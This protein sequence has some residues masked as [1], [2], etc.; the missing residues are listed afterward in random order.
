MC[1]LSPSAGTE[2]ERQVG[3]R[4]RTVKAA[5]AEVRP[6]S[7]LVAD[8]PPGGALSGGGV[9]GDH[10]M[11]PRAELPWHGNTDQYG[12]NTIR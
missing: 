4:K 12:A 7:A 8:A 11:R 6:I 1:P 9:M 10:P 2:C 5:C 3:G